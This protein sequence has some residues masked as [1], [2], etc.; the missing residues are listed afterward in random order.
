M[1]ANDILASNGVGFR[2][3]VDDLV[4]IKFEHINGYLNVPEGPGL[5]VELD[6]EALKKYKE[7]HWEKI[8]GPGK[9]GVYTSPSY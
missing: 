1:Y 9:K 8:R 6:E 7:E 3:S 5:G 2:G 4:D